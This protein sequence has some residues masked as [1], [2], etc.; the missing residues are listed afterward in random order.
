MRG[1]KL[2][3]VSVRDKLSQGG[4]ISVPRHG[5]NSELEQALA[6]LVN[7]QAT[8]AGNQA[9]FLSQLART[10]ERFS[11]IENELSEIKAILLRHERMIQSLPEAVREKIGFKAR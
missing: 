4:L 5:R 11:R 7:S 1:E 3:K 9:T 2:R 8:L 6:T 10:D